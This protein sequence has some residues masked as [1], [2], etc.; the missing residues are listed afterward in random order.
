MSVTTTA[1]TPPGTYAVTITG[2][3]TSPSLTHS[4]TVTLV[5]TSTGSPDFSISASP[6][7]QTVARGNST[8]YTVTVAP[9][10]GFNGTVTFRV[11]GLPSGSSASFNPGSV[12]GQGTSTLTVSTSASTP[13]GTSTL[14]IRGTSGGG[15]NH[16][17]TVQLVVQ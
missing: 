17:T 10:N 6:S 16:N 14:R 11:R 13:T 1:S 15:A 3:S 9:I 5:V 2:I 8:S 4:T 7:S 12:T